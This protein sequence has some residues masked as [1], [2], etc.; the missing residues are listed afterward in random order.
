MVLFIMLNNLVLPFE[1]VN[2]NSTA[3]LFGF[4]LSSRALIKGKEIIL[5]FELASKYVTFRSLRVS[6]SATH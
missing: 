3:V 1:S 2:G 5:A 4:Q 6:W